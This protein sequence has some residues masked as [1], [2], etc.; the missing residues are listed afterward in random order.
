MPNAP[1]AQRACK[2][3]AGMASR[4]SRGPQTSSQ[5][6]PSGYMQSKRMGAKGRPIGKFVGRFALFGVTYFV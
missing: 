5:L 1:H 2:N 3:G 6:R 4:G